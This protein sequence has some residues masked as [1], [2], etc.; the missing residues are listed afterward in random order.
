MFQG[1]VNAVKQIVCHVRISGCDSL[2]PYHSFLA[3]F[4]VVGK[5][6]FLNLLLSK[7]F[8]IKI[9]G[10]AYKIDRR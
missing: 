3:T 10:N 9:G 2:L 8:L 5:V 7:R 1:L 4:F 6:S